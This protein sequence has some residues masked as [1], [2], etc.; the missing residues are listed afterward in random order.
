V[1]HAWTL[2]VLDGR[3]QVIR[4]VINPDKLGYLGP[5]A[6]AWA[7]FAIEKQPWYT[8][9]EVVELSQTVPRPRRENLPLLRP[10]AA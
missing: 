2:D 8:H 3:I 7:E 10:R 5:V 1:L 6:D 4:P 9:R